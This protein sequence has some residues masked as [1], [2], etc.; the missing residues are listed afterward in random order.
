[1]LSRAIDALAKEVVLEHRLHR[2]LWVGQL[3]LRARY[4]DVSTNLFQQRVIRW[5]VEFREVKNDVFRIAAQEGLALY[6]VFDIGNMADLV[7]P[8]GIQKPVRWAV[9]RGRV[10]TFAQA[11]RVTEQSQRFLN[12]AYEL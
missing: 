5:S 6:E 9:S 1:M 2:L 4:S 8:H 3:L 7:R 12:I 11:A 10:K